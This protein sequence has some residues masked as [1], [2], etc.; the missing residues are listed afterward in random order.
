MS[1]SKG[2]ILWRNKKII[3]SISPFTLLDY[4]GHTS[5]I[6]WFSGCNMRCA[7]CYNYD[8]VLEPSQYSLNDIDGFLKTRQGLLDAVVL[9]GGEPT[10]HK[11]LPYIIDHIKD[12][13]F[14]VKLD[15]NGSKPRMIEKLLKRDEVDYYALDFKAPESS[16]KDITASNIVFEEFLTSLLYLIHSEV[17]FE[18]R[19][20]YHSGL[21][22]LNDIY[23]IL[24]LLEDL[25]YKKT[26]YIQKFVNS[27]NTMGCLPIATNSID[28]PSTIDTSRYSFAIK[29][30]NF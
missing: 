15:T 27:F 8:V 10:L 26:Y 7:Y 1:I 30:R 5:A 25:G 22:S 13:G 3:N 14:K 9:C 18:V 2:D 11:E 19:T 28:I 6:L 17:D 23:E 4:E 24:G 16:F 29:Y 21:L 12:M 20:T